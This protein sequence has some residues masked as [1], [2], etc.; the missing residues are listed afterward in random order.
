MNHR[1]RIMPHGTGA[2]RGRNDR[3]A[4]LIHVTVMMLGLLAFSAFSIDHGVM[5]VSRGQAQNAADAGAMAAALYLAYDGGDQPGA[6]AIGV[7]AAQANGVWGAQPDITLTDVTFPT[8]SAGIA[9]HSGHLREG[10]CLPESARRRES[11]AGVLLQSG[12]RGEPGGQ[13]D[14]DDTDGL[15]SLCDLCSPV[16]R[17][18]PLA[19]AP[20]GRGGKHPG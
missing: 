20:R 13:G 4:V 7:A 12:R 9:Q 8:L 3:G 11:V 2:T 18:G 17:P 5:M 10:R 15:F 19:R 6:Q 16:L 1:L 14:G